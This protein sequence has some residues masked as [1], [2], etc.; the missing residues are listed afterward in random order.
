M[1]DW[2][3]EVQLKRS[4]HV[5]LQQRDQRLVRRVGS[6]DPLALAEAITARAYHGFRRTEMGRQ[7]LN[8]LH[9]RDESAGAILQSVMTTVVMLARLGEA[10]S[11]DALDEV[12]VATGIGEA[13]D[14]SAQSGQTG[15]DPSRVREQMKMTIQRLALGAL[16]QTFQSAQLARLEEA[17]DAVRSLAGTLG[18]L[19]EESWLRLPLCRLIPLAVVQEVV[20]EPLFIT[21]FGTP[22][23]LVAADILGTTPADLVQ[24]ARDALLTPMSK[25]TGALW[26]R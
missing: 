20:S 16:E 2:S 19:T 7:W 21:V 14:E 23:M 5:W 3:D 4:H 8:R 22:L 18:G 17:R 6:R 1:G 9:G 12:L 24:S 15:A 11:D 10:S 25:S 13:L 26:N